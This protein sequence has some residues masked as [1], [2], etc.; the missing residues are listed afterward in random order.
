MH[1]VVE[2]CF[3]LFEWG[4][5]EFLEE[6][7]SEEMP[8][9]FLDPILYTVIKIPIEI[10]DVEEIMDQYTI[11]NHLTFNITNPFTNKELT[12]KQLIE[13][14]NQEEVKVRLENF[15]NEFTQWKMK[16]KI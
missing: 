6:I 2:R 4:G 3:A 14:N 5:E 13:Y 15:K 10:P 16:F 8:S 11:M 7:Y 1:G 9:K 12:K